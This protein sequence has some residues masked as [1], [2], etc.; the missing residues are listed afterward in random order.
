[1][2]EW[3][4]YD[5][6]SECGYVKSQQ[7]ERKD[8]VC[9]IAWWD[10]CVCGLACWLCDIM[11]FL[12]PSSPPASSSCRVF[13]WEIGRFLGEFNPDIDYSQNM[14]TICDNFPFPQ[15]SYS[16]SSTW[17]P[18]SSLPLFL[19]LLFRSKHSSLSSPFLQHF[20]FPAF[21]T[22]L[23]RIGPTRSFNGEHIPQFKLRPTTLH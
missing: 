12:L 5:H 6:Q 23:R 1:M 22:F 10:S 7:R 14:F 18:R 19:L 20:Q 9:R 21:S 13:F 4:W 15:S 11:S 17:T 8:A 16:P 2:D 3:V